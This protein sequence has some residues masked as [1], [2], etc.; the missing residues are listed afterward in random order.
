MAGGKNFTSD[1]DEV[2]QALEPEEE[3]NNMV[4]RHFSQRG[5]DWDLDE[6]HNIIEE[7][8]IIDSSNGANII[9]GRQVP[10]AKA[11][12]AIYTGIAEAIDEK[13]EG[14]VELRV[15]PFTSDM[16]VKNPEKL[17]YVNIPF[18]EDGE[19][20]EVSLGSMNSMNTI[21][22]HS[23]DLNGERQDLRDRTGANIPTGKNDLLSIHGSMVNGRVNHAGDISNVHSSVIEEMMSNDMPPEEVWLERPEGS[24]E[25]LSFENGQYTDGEN[26]YD[27]QD[28]IENGF[29]SAQDAY[30]LVLYPLSL[31]E[32][33]IYMVRIAYRKTINSTRRLPEDWKQE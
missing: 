8:N 19:L 28:V 9:V 24:A 21:G 2:I 4:D 5:I 15:P 18:V 20:S 33:T 23:Y 10:T 31:A 3:A 1:I 7:E 29:L 17:S 30:N 13:V 27:A 6:F 26:T 25:R 11:E 32:D 14:C 12:T 22:S 16:M